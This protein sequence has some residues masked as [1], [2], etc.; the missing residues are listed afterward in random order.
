MKDLNNFA[1]QFEEEDNENDLNDN[2]NKIKSAPNKLTI[3]S[4]IS[5]LFF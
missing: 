4:L 2:I 1:D 5:L 3:S